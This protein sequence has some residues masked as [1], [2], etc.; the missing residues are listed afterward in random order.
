M[1]VRILSSKHTL[2][3][4]VDLMWW[5]MGSWKNECLHFEDGKVQC[6]LTNSDF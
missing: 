1:G 6:K 2:R 5:V 3:S 4:N